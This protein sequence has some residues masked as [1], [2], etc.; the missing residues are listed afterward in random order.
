M[1]KGPVIIHLDS[2][3]PTAQAPF[4]TSLPSYT[5]QFIQSLQDHQ[6]HLNVVANRFNQSS[7]ADF[8]IWTV[9]NPLSFPLF[10]LLTK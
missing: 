5:G 3:V 2:C 8:E 1:Q 10:P 7:F 9:F 6:H 4:L